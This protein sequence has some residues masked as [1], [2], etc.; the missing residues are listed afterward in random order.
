MFI[1][2][3]KCLYIKMKSINKLRE[4]ETQAIVVVSI[5]TI[6]QV[7]FARSGLNRNNVIY[8]K[9]FFMSPNSSEYLFALDVC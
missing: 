3:N 8:L 7:V 2:V 6:T 9:F 1:N 4:V 5:A